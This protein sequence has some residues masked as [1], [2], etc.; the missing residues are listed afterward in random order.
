[1][2]R[3]FYAADVPLV[4]ARNPYFA[5]MVKEIASF[6]PGYAPP[7]SEALRTTLLATERTAI[8]DA[9]GLI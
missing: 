9:L 1:M 7:S 6:G 3:F 8:E 5:D 4:K 2:A